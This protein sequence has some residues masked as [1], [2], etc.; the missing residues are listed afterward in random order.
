MGDGA[1]FSIDIAVPASG[2]SATVEAAR[3]MERLTNKLTFAESAALKAAGAVQAGEAAY[4]AAENAANK[5]SLAVEKITAAS[6]AQAAKAAKAAA[7]Y[8]IFSAQAT[9]A[10]VKLEALNARQAEAA[11][12]SAA[13]TAAMNAEA[14]AL[15]KLKAASTTAAAGQ[16]QV[17]KALEQAKTKAAE[18]SKSM[19]KL[20]AAKVGPNAGEA[21]AALGQLGG[22]LGA[23]GGKAFQAA[24]AFKKMGSSLGAAGPYVAAAVAIVAIATAVSA[25]A[26]AMG[27]A[28]IKTA[29][30][31][32]GL[33]NVART[34]GLLSAGITKSLAGGA[35]LDA[36][37]DELQ[38]RVPA[39]RDEL[40]SMAS[41][42]AA[43]GLKG[44]ALADALEEAAAKAARLKFGPDFE[45]E[46]LSLNQQSKRLKAGVAGIFGG[47]QI[48]GLLTELSKLVG[49]FDKSTVSG[50]AIKV[51]FESLFQPLIDGVTA[52]IPK[53]VSGFIQFQI[54]VLKALIAIKPFGSTIMKVAQVFGILAVVVAAM[55]IGFTVAVI[56]PFAIIIGLAAAVIAGIWALVSS[57]V[58]AGQ[59]AIG[60]GTS[61][62]ASVGA[63]LEWLSSLSL[64]EIGTALIDGLI[65][66]ITG[67]G[68]G[69]LSAITGIAGGAVN[70]AK[71]MLQINSPSRVFAEIGGQTAEGMAVGLDA[72]AGDVQDAMAEVAAP[73][74]AA[75]GGA[76][77]SASGGGGGA[78]DLSG[79]TFVFQGVKG[80]EDALDMLRAGI[81]E[82]LTQAGGGAPEAA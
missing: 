70:A 77:A 18:A 6:D 44:S 81:A 36:Q 27:I 72:G 80:A 25:V 61:L 68:A 33:A 1:S 16:T 65:A 20:A 45:R 76:S 71:S 31:A 21:A 60:F 56:A 30:W 48:E 40:V 32:V 78:V 28:V 62:M 74:A 39:T 67:A 49:L 26:V 53:M 24:D 52:W 34:Q 10:Q 19:Q 59:S 23:V 37:L 4:K 9:R 7:E 69:V 5:A 38:M 29:A 47:L 41:T 35:A 55:A 79:A 66:G 64:A 46:M 17:A 14:T 8:G 75:T 82:I 50:K 54:L 2:I 42:L 13:A 58:S 15:D 43:T 3:A 11:T 51:V 12:K 22:P 63:A 73:P 57:L